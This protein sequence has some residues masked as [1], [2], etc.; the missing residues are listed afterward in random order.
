MVRLVAYVLVGVTLAACAGCQTTRYR[1]AQ[2]E[3]GARARRL[4]RNYAEYDRKGPQRLSTVVGFER[5]V[6]ERSRKSLNETLKL[7]EERSAEDRRQWKAQQKVREEWARRVLL[8]HPE[9]IDETWAD[10]TY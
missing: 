9:K 7:I 8:A 5:R 1:E 6:H 4:A 3:R 2:A 10:M